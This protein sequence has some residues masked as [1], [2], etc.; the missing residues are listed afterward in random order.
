MYQQLTGATSQTNLIEVFE[1]LRRA[2][3]DN[4]LPA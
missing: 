1:N 2:S 4:H 3:Q